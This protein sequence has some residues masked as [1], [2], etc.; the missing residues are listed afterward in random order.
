MQNKNFLIFVAEYMYCRSHKYLYLYPMENIKEILYS[1]IDAVILY[2]VPALITIGI[3]GALT[4]ILW[5][6]IEKV[7]KWR[8]KEQQLWLL[9]SGVRILSGQA[10]QN[11]IRHAMVSTILPFYFSTTVPISKYLYQ[12]LPSSASEA[13]LR[14]K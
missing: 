8:K 14:Q 12:N 3:L 7:K 9:W 2:A 10:R 11:V 6:C 13:I 4:A 1:L 5:D